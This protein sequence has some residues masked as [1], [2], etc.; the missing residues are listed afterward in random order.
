MYRG[1]W[2][3]EYPF[4]L[5]GP[6]FDKESKPVSG[7]DG[8]SDGTEEWAVRWTERRAG[9]NK[10]TSPGKISHFP[11]LNHGETSET[12]DSENL[13]ETSS[14]ADQC[15]IAAD[16]LGRGAVAGGYAPTISVSAP[17]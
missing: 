13:R 11:A 10:S 16:S 1:R 9:K 15:R 3:R 14:S 12:D 8:I 17:G 2:R 5:R 4:Q 6:L 7:K